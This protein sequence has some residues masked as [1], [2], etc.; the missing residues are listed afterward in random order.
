[1]NEAER[2]LIKETGGRRSALLAECLRLRRE[3]VTLY[4]MLIDSE[5]WVIKYGQYG[6][7]RKKLGWTEEEIDQRL[8]NG[9]GRD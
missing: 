9:T 8:R 1:M 4:E 2:A 6:I 3:K 7:S 5:H